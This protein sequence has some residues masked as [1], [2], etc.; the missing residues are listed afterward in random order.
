MFSTNF[1]LRLEEKLKQVVSVA[2]SFNF[3]ILS[4]NFQ[5]FKIQGFLPRSISNS[6]A[7]LFLL[8]SC[9]TTLLFLEEKVFFH[10]LS[11]IQ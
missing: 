4:K 2:S 10:H 5:S 8:S 9:K 11:D 1:H 6:L 3:F 7:R